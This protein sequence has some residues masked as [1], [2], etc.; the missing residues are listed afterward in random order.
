MEK[1]LQLFNNLFLS[2]ADQHV[3][4]RKFTVR[5]QKAS[6]IEE[7]LRERMH[8]RDELKQAAIGSKETEKW[9]MFCVMRNKVTN[10]NRLKKKAHF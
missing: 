5:S 7:E 8:E 2:L 6:W 9:Q 3:P 4:L 10:L 1:A